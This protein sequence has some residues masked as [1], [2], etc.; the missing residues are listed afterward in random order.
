MGKIVLTVYLYAIFPFSY[1]K[2]TK[3]C[4]PLYQGA[5]LTIH[6]CPFLIDIDNEGNFHEFVGLYTTVVMQTK[7]VIRFRPSKILF[8]ILK[9][10][11][12][13]SWKILSLYFFLYLS[14]Y[15]RS[16]ISLFLQNTN[17]S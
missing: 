12:L 15:A 14:Y 4:P 2:G 17:V 11:Y 1:E 8:E 13:I 5:E 10:A 9:R 3:S 16:R 7:R 6:V